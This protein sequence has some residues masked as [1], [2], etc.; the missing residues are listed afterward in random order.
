M[1]GGVDGSGSCSPGMVVQTKNVPVQV[2][3][4]VNIVQFVPTVEGL[5]SHGCVRAFDETNR[6]YC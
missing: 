6:I 3:F 5:L 2:L 1:A 4:I